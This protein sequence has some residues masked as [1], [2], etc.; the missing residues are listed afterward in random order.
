M[1]VAQVLKVLVTVAA[2][3]PVP[4]QMARL[5]LQQQAVTV[6]RVLLTRYKQTLLKRMAAAAAVDRLS[7]LE[8]VARV[9]VALVVFLAL[10]LQEPQIL[11]AVPVAVA[12]LAA[13]ITAAL[14][15]QASSSF[16]RSP[17]SAGQAHPLRVAR[18]RLTRV[19]VRTVC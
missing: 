7:L 2:A 1:R 8:L 10:E 9:V 3:V 11:V 4:L 6:E 19:M 18:S 13:P 12:V 5:V 17:A 14:A 15:A 16:A